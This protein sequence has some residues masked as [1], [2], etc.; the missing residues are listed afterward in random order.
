VS[1]LPF[2]S[3]FLYY[4]PRLMFHIAGLFRIFNR[5]KKAFRKALE[6]EGLPDDVVEV[7]V[8]GLSPDVEWKELLRRNM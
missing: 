3:F 8:E 7:L 2:L 6:K 1:V 5:G 4:L